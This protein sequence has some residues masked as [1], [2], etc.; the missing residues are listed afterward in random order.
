MIITTVTTDNEAL[1]GFFPCNDCLKDRF[2]K[3]QTALSHSDKSLKDCG[4][5][6]VEN[7]CTVVFFLQ[8]E[9]LILHKS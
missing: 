3:C 8:L 5:G 6:N 4:G 7:I 1:T 9:D 2:V